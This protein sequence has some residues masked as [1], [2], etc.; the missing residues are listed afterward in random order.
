MRIKVKTAI[1][2]PKTTLHPPIFVSFIS[3]K[4]CF[5]NLVKSWDWIWFS[6][7]LSLGKGSQILFDLQSGK[8]AISCPQGR[9]TGGT[10]FTKMTK[11]KPL[12]TVNRPVRDQYPFL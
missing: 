7:F 9:S 3:G 12:I 6:P 2:T 11:V 5:G 1:D 10:F 4:F 8:M